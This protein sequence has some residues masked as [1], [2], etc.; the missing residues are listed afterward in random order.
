MLLTVC[1]ISG[2]VLDSDRVKESSLN[3]TYDPGVIVF[4]ATDAMQHICRV[5][6]DCQRCDRSPIRRTDAT[7]ARCPPLSAAGRIE[8]TMTARARARI[9]SHLLRGG[10]DI[11]R[12]L[13]STSEDQKVRAIAACWV[14]GCE[15]RDG[16]WMSV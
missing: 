11:Q 15:S 13:E 3:T 16:T 1:S 5:L 9:Q 4:K 10:G 2:G 7:T 6:A 14:S 8:R 12:L